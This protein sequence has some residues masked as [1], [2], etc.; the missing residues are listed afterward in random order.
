M[1]DWQREFPTEPGD[2]LW[3]EMW[4]CGSCVHKCGIAWVDDDGNFIDEETGRGHWIS[5]EPTLIDGKP[6]FITAW[7][8]IELPPKQW[9]DV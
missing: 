6:E 1:S 9:A 4:P 2:W 7:R 8:R 3:V 5:G